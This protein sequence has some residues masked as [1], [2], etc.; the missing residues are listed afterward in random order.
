MF[1]VQMPLYLC[2]YLYLI[3]ISEIFSEDANESSDSRRSSLCKD[4]IQVGPT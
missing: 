3:V 1:L 4:M 2:S